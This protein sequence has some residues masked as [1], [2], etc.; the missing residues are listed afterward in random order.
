MKNIIIGL[1]AIFLLAACPAPRLHYGVERV[2]NLQP[3]VTTRQDLI[4]IFGMPTFVS[5]NSRGQLLNWQYAPTA[6]VNG[7]KIHFLSVDVD[8]EGVMVRI[9][10][11]VLQ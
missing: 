2:D 6:E 7:E 9:H 10:R 5:S 1:V 8:S 4:R 3:G 11:L